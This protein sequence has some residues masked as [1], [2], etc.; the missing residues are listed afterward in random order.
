MDIL[1]VCPSQE[2]I[3]HAGE[4]VATLHLYSDVWYELRKLATYTRVKL[5]LFPE[6]QNLNCIYLNHHSFT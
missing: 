1:I 4:R 6:S 5:C 2:A 3:V